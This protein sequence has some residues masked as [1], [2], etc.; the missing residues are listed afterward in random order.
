MAAVMFLYFGYFPAYTVHMSHT[1]LN[2][3]N[4][5]SHA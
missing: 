2:N 1:L 5:A 3:E 4:E